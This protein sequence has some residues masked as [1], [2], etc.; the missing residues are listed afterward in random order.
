MVADQLGSSPVRMNGPL[1]LYSLMAH[2]HQLMKLM[3]W[4]KCGWTVHFEKTKL[5][6]VFLLWVLVIV[7]PSTQNMNLLTLIDFWVLRSLHPSSSIFE[8]NF[9]YHLQILRDLKSIPSIGLVLQG[10][11]MIL[12]MKTHLMD[13]TKYIQ[14]FNLLTLRASNNFFVTCKAILNT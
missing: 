14:I 3:R 4:S 13:M 10:L 6:I 5:V 8:Q 9:P 1:F 12:T 2:V 11:S 7:F